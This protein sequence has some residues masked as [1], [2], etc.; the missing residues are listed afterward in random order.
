VSI[1]RAAFLICLVAA[2]AIS[3]VAAAPPSCATF[4]HEHR[5]WT[6]LLEQYVDGGRVDYAGLH[7]DAR[8]ALSAYL[9]VLSAVSRTCYAEWTR[10]QRLSF[11]I[12]TYNAHAVELILEHYPVRSVRA[13]GWLPG[14]A[15]R[16]KFIPMKDLAGGDLSLDDV[17]H[18][19]LRKE[20][21]EPRIHFAIVCASVSCPSLRSKAY[22]ATD[23]DRQLDDQARRFL[24]DPTKNR[25]DAK[26][27]TVGLSSIFKWFREDF[28]EAAGSL[29]AFVARYVDPATAAALREP[30]VR[31]E[32]L[33]YDWSLNGK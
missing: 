8:P 15:F 21:H 28:E 33:D 17:E 2:G 29:P 23:L 11:W 24:A 18:E 20:F 13:I 16:T 25:F 9:H 19:H 12:N 32:F 22:R 10:E 30:G 3:P 5:A 6:H 27:G 31:I 14:A 26:S 4:D 1:Q 7:R